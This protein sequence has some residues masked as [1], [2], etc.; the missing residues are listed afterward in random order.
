MKQ[1][2]IYQETLKMNKFK[3]RNKKFRKI[4]KEFGLTDEIE[5]I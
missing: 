4:N 1:S 3:E 2:K 5:N